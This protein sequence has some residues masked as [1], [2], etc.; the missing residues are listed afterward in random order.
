[1]DL[2]EKI[3]VLADSAAGD[4]GQGL[5]RAL[6]SVLAEIA[7]FDAGEAVLAAGERMLRWRLDDHEGELLGA[8]VIRHI[9]PLHAPLRF[10]ELEDAAAFPETRR[11]MEALGLR[12]L[13]VLPFQGGGAL[14]VARRY[15]WAFV[16]ASLHHLWPVR[17]MA[18]IGLRQAV[19]LTGLAQKV[20][21]QEAELERA[22]ATP[23]ELR[24][25]LERAQAEAREREAQR[26]AA[27]AGWEATRAE[28]RQTA[29]T[30]AAAEEAARAA[31]DGEERAVAQ[32]AE[33]A[34]RIAEEARKREA[35]EADARRRQAEADER[36]GR[37]EGERHALVVEVEALRRERETAQGREQGADRERSSLRT[38]LGE[39]EARVHA[40]E[41]RLAELET[42][43]A[44][45]AHARD[46]A[47]SEAE[48][49]DERRREEEALRTRLATEIAALEADNRVL[50]SELEGAR[51]EAAGHRHAAQ[52]ALARLSARI[53]RPPEAPHRPSAAR[54]KRRRFPR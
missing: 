52:E 50:R 17:G 12:S 25:R 31:R 44:A 42:A 34:G 30:L 54:A 8:D 45:S 40:L 53:E 49:W 6:R 26:A 29:R 23:D 27:N 41:T 43:L 10:D 51:N 20:E 1:M 2:A 13:L 19:L 22:N 48:R 47:R 46:E 36:L 28:L 33:Q 16:G 9:G 18:G 11:A 24:A 35:A 3:L 39:Q 15:G 38:A 21:A 32:A 14:A 5:V 7:P 37:A 4:G